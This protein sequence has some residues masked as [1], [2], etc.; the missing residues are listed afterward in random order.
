MVD[1]GI[2]SDIMESPSPKCYMAFWD[3]TICSDTLN[4]S[5]I[6]PI[7]ELITELDLIT[8]FDLVTKFRRF[9]WSIATG[10]ASQQRTLAALGAWLAFVLMLRPFLPELV[11]STNLSSFEHPSVL[12]YCSIKTRKVFIC[13]GLG[14]SMKIKIKIRLWKKTRGVFHKFRVHVT[15]FGYEVTIELYRRRLTVGEIFSSLKICKL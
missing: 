13:L 7:C 6:T 3:M 8:Y 15:V 2:S 12:L 4:W 11:M 1:V 10:A 14:T 9:P 5:D